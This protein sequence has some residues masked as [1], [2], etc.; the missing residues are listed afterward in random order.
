VKGE[1]QELL[2]GVDQPVHGKNLVREV[3]QAKIL[4]S[5][6]RRGAMIPLAFHGGTA[7]RF[8]FS[9][10]RFSEDLDFALERPEAG[11]DFRATLEAV[12][13]DLE[14][15]HYEVGIRLRE[16]KVV[17]VARVQFPGLLYELG[18][19]AQRSENLTIKV[20]VDTR[21][22]RGALLETTLVRRHETLRLQH[23]D[24]ASLLA[25]KLHAILQRPY[26][27]G[28][29]LYDLVWYLGDPDW[30]GPNLE[31]LNNAL[32]QTGWTGGR[33]TEASWRG[34][35]RERVEEFDWDRAV[36]DLRPFVRSEG[37]LGLVQVE[38]VRDL[39]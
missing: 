25:G 37:A 1:L 7:L 3:L 9:L 38:V 36:A 8:L 15:E 2:R 24:R 11:F 26:T 17:R 16:A 21:P 5:L 31:L 18:L 27:K 10:D 28:R 6:Q 13:A 19:P 33:L 23:H 29:D 14:R 30:P 34:A 39:L 20:E 32:E 35:V 4:A 12:R 22:P